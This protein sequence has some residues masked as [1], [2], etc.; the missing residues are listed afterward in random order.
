MILRKL[1]S[2]VKLRKNI[3]W[4]SFFNQNTLDLGLNPQLHQQLFSSGLAS[5]LPNP[6]PGYNPPQQSPSDLK[7]VENK[8]I[9]HDEDDDGPDDAKVELENMDLWDS[10]HQFGTEMVITKTGR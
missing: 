3:G 10:F 8:K 4:I 6:I 1:R 7:K 9:D 2:I 5:R